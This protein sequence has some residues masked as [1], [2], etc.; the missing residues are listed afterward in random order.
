MSHNPVVEVQGIS[1]FFWKISFFFL[2]PSKLFRNALSA[3]HDHLKALETQFFEKIP[4][5]RSTG[6]P[7]YA[8]LGCFLALHVHNLVVEVQGISKFLQKISVFFKHTPNSLE[9]HFRHPTTIWKRW[10]RIFSKKSPFWGLRESRFRLFY[11]DFWPTV[12]EKPVVEVQG[13]LKFF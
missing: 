5:F 9:I 3:S 10:R 11:A 12:F 8:I 2:T 6:E 1:E 7:T 13:I 4:I